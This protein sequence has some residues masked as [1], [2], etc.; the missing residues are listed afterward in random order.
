[1]KR[2]FF[3]NRNL[4]IKCWNQIINRLTF[5][6]RLGVDL[7]GVCVRFGAFLF[8]AALLSALCTKK[9]NNERRPIGTTIRMAV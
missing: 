2:L 9:G 3:E 4:G 7:I 5:G 1:M 6:A 8:K